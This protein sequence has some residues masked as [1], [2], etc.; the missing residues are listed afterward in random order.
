MNHGTQHRASWLAT[1]PSADSRDAPGRARTRW[2]GDAARPGLSLTECVGFGEH[3]WSARDFG[4]GRRRSPTVN[5]PRRARR[6]QGVEPTANTARERSVDDPGPSARGRSCPS[7]PA[8]DPVISPSYKGT[9]T[10]CAAVWTGGRLRPAPPRH[11]CRGSPRVVPSSPRDPQPPRHRVAPAI[12][13]V[14][15]R[16]RADRRRGSDDAAE[17]RS[18]ISWR[19]RPPTI[20][21]APRDLEILPIETDFWRFY[22][23]RP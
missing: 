20:E 10:R 12:P 11:R 13:D 19:A 23:L 9:S 14:D 17:R 21:G 3:A 22:R 7:V 1:S 8:A 2:P 16:L 18:I 15:R 6:A 4:A 5:R